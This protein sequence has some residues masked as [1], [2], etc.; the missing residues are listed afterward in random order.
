MELLECVGPSPRE[1]GS[2]LRSQLA[3]EWL[4][5]EGRCDRVGAWHSPR[6]ACAVH[7]LEP[8]GLRGEARCSLACLGHCLRLG[9]ILLVRKLLDCEIQFERATSVF[10]PLPVAES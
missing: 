4:R 8:Y 7:G 10:C 6:A 2:A 3:A 5:V 9:R 1:D